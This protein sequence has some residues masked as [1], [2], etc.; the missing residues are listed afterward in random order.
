MLQKKKKNGLVILYMGS[1][2]LEYLDYK[3]LINKISTPKKK[4]TVKKGR[5]TR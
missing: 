3:I 2:I 1:E 5:R 4:F